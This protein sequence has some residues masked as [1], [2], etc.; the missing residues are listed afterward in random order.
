MGMR[1]VTVAQQLGLDLVGLC[2]A[3]EATRSAAAETLRLDPSVFFSDAQSMLAR[4]KPAVVVIATT[5]P[6]H[7]PL[8]TLA[9]QAG[10][11]H[12]LCEKP[13]ATSLRACDAMIE[14]CARSG[15]KLAVNH[16]MRFMEQ[17]TRPKELV[18]TPAFGGLAGVQVMAGN[19]GIAMNGT[20]YF[21][22][23]RYLTDEAPVRV[24]AWFSSERVP[25]PRGAQ[26]EDAAGCIRLETA[27]GKRFYMDCSADQ[28]HGMFVVYSGR[29]GR[30]AVDELTG[31]MT[32]IQREAEHRS[33]PTTR[34]GMPFETER[35]TV[36]PADAVAP[37]KSVLE[38]LLAGKDY[39]TGE[40]GR[41]A[42]EVLVASHVSAREGSRVV[43]LDREA[44]PRDLTLPIA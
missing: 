39:P 40:D 22:M 32:L 16:Q 30:L 25:N 3:A 23:F 7:E 2:D 21:E 37:T 34:Y 9:A 1:H 18:N 38:A 27:S 28:G 10:A 29:N 13:L 11:T 24:S 42:M 5:A 41:L 43:S 44:L 15:A 20:H 36:T 14:A 4:A 35:L 19:F 6:S 26:F 33:L 31:D 8:V 12:I 17:Y